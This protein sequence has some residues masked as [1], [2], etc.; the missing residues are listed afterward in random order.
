MQHQFQY[1][2][3]TPVRVSPAQGAPRPATVPQPA[4]KQR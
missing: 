1:P 4:P 2:Q 3:V